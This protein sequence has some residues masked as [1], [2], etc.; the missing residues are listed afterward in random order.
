MVARYIQAFPSDFNDS[1]AAVLT[2]VRTLVA[3]DVKASYLKALQGYVWEEGYASSK[4]R[5]KLFGDVLPSFQRW[6]GERR[7]IIIYSSGSVP[8]QKLLFKYTTEEHNSG[9]LCEFISGWYDTVKAGM[10]QEQSSY[11]KIVTS[12]KKAGSD[13]EAGEWCFFSD[14]LKEIEAATAAGLQ[15]VLTFRPGNGPVPE[16]EIEKHRNCNSFANVDLA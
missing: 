7:R 14:N 6:A 15:A 2:H 10:K 3:A 9:D 5:C 13:I 4:I 1:P 16:M 11:E 8:A 12:E